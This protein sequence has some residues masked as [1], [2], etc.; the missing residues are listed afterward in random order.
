MNNLK[1]LLKE[2]GIIPSHQR[3]KVLEYLFANRIHPTASEVYDGLIDDFGTLSKATIY[4]T[5]NLF[6][7]KGIIIS[8]LIEGNEARFDIN[9]KHH[10][11]FKCLK[12]GKIYDIALKNELFKNKMIDKYKITEYHVNFKGICENCLNEN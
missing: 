1:I 9:I 11:H 6:L 8:V 3:I 7:E 12:C 5:L 4:N 2:A 10:G